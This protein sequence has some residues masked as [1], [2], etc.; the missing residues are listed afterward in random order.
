MSSV[1]ILTTGFDEPSVDTIILKRATKSLAL[2]YQMIGRGSR[3]FGKKTKF[4]IIDLGNN[5]A[6]FGSWNAPVDWHEI[7]RVPDFYLQGIVTDLEIERNFKYTKTILFLEFIHADKP[8]IP[9]SS[10]TFGPRM[11][12]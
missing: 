11:T 12:K 2:Y 5:V 4:T 8:W 3:V 10:L 9:G 1:S 6:R 7:F